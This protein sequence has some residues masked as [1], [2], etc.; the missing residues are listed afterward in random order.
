MLERLESTFRFVK[1][2]NLPVGTVKLAYRIYAL[3]YPLS[4]TSQSRVQRLTQIQGPL[5]F[6]ALLAEG[7][8]LGRCLY[9]QKGIT[10]T[11]FS[12]AKRGYRVYH[13]VKKNVGI[14]FSRNG[15]ILAKGVGLGSNWVVALLR[16]YESDPATLSMEKRIYQIFKLIKATFYI[17]IQYTD[18]KWLKRYFEP[19]IVGIDF[20]HQ[21]YVLASRCYNLYYP[22]S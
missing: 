2:L 10:F 8:H 21:G 16:L 20:M 19:I 22:K 5:V 13:W 1:S 9:D 18:Y 14:K 12:C 4:D 17:V 6:S 3:K 7:L 15:T 11:V